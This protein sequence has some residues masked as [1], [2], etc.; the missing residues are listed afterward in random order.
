LG[1]QPELLTVSQKVQ[2]GL[3]VKSSTIGTCPQWYKSNRTR[4]N[5][6]KLTE[7]RSILKYKLFSRPFPSVT[8][9]FAKASA[10]QARR[11]DAKETKRYLFFIY[12]PATLFAALRL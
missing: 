8:P 9:A 6:Q 1:Y 2:A 12:K 4:G 3:F 5:R 11:Q 7:M 10:W